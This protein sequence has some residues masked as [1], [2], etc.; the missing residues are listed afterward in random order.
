MTIISFHQ[1]VNLSQ[2]EDVNDR[3][4][5][6]RLLTNFIANEKT[7]KIVLSLLKDENWRV[8]KS[9]IETIITLKTPSLLQNVVKALYNDDNAGA[10][11]AAMDILLHLGSVSLPYLKSE[12]NTE[13]PD[14]KL[15][16]VTLL[17]DLKDIT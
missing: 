1:I 12:Y 8:R 4:E 17:G 5:A 6:A 10:R 13:H 2:S 7:E 15:F 3:E 11:N 9:A 16:L 14:V